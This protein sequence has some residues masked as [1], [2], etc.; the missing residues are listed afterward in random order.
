[1]A[2][3]RERNAG[4]KKERKSRN[5]DSAK[6]VQEWKERNH[7]NQGGAETMETLQKILRK[8]RGRRILDHVRGAVVVVEGQKKN[9]HFPSASND[10]AYLIDDRGGR[11]PSRTKKEKKKKGRGNLGT[12]SH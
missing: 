7:H 1:V 4:R 2:H 8:K 6:G 5:N 9:G 12:F 10:E 3:K 11:E